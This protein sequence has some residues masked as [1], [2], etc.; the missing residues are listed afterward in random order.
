[1]KLAAWGDEIKNTFRPDP[2]Y[3]M[4]ETPAAVYSWALF[5]T[6]MHY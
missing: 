1:M 3:I 4:E 5:G 2:G 6:Q